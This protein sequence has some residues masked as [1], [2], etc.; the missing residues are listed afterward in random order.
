M[1]FRLPRI[2]IVTSDEQGAANMGELK[3]VYKRQPPIR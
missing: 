1:A 2:S 3:D